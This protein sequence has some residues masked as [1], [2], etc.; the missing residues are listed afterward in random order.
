MTS[1]LDFLLTVAADDD[2]TA[3]LRL[4]AATALVPYHSARKKP[5]ARVTDEACVAELFGKLLRALTREEKLLYQAALDRAP[6]ATEPD[7]QFG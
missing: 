2:A 1:A 6:A 7:T 4:S 5:V 3:A